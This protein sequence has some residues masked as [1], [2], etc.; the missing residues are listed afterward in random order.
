MG[1]SFNDDDPDFLV[2]GF[3]NCTGLSIVYLVLSIMFSVKGQN[4]AF[5]NTMKLLTYEVRPENPAEY[6]HDYMKQVQH[7]EKLGCFQMFRLPGM[8]E[9]YELGGA[10][11]KLT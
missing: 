11:G 7:I 6:N 3:F 8:K 9:R 10:K 4:C 2:H 5:T 1:V